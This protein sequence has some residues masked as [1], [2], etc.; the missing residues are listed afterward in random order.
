MVYQNARLV[1]TLALALSPAGMWAQAPAQRDDRQAIEQEIQELRK[2][3]EDLDQRL[4][5]F[6]AT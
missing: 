3:L 1:V 4:R 5:A 2:R 6:D